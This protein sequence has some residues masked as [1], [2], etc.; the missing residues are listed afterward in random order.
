MEIGW[1][2]RRNRRISGEIVI[3]TTCISRYVP[4]RLIDGAHKSSSE[5]GGSFPPFLYCKYSFLMDF[6]PF[7]FHFFA[8]TFGEIK[9]IR[10]RKKGRY[11][12][13]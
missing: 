11:G 12:M 2:L 5:G 10:D 7:P 4:A 3:S 9:R 13:P 6:F 1:S 8:S